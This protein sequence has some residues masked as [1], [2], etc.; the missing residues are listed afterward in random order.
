M[1]KVMINL[2]Q[3]KLCDIRQRLAKDGEDE[4]LHS[5]HKHTR[6]IGQTHMEK[7]AHYYIKGSDHYRVGLSIK[8]LQ[9]PPHFQLQKLRMHKERDIK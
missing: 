2:K 3:S 8:A 5:N 9:L 7:H 6:K 4:L 1:Q